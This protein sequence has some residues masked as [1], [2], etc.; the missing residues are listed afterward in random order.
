MKQ[1]SKCDGRNHFLS[2]VNTV[3]AKCE[4]GVQFVN[5]VTYGKITLKNVGDL[6]R[7]KIMDINDELEKQTISFFDLKQFPFSVSIQDLLLVYLDEAI[8]R[9]DKLTN[10]IVRTWKFVSVL[11]ADNLILKMAHKVVNE[12]VS[13]CS[14]IQEFDWQRSLDDILT[15]RYCD[16][17]YYIFEP[18][19]YQQMFQDDIAFLRNIGFD[20]ELLV[21]IQTKYLPIINEQEK[22]T[23][24]FS[25]Q[26]NNEVAKL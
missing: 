6:Y 23:M 25:K 8:N 1:W 19:S 3:A 16:N 22:E 5:K 7:S 20:N 17:R 10:I 14:Y 9:L 26:N 12:Y 2:K 21:S 24:L 18:G 4:Q 13:C 11:G 15:F